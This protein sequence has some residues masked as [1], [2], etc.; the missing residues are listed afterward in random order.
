MVSTTVYNKAKGIFARGINW[1][2]ED[3]RALLI[4]D[5]I[6]G[7]V[8]DP[9]HVSLDEVLAGNEEWAGTGYS[10]PTLATSGRTLNVSNDDDKVYLQG[11]SVSFGTLS[12]DGAHEIT[13]VVFYWGS[14]TAEDG[15]ALTNVPL[16]CHW[17]GDNFTPDGTPFVVGHAAA[18][19]YVTLE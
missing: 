16:V 8:F 7:S 1:A 11:P 19:G 18:S 13:H 12:A 6:E 17:L 5:G 4:R 10:R 2:D 9:D 3:I 15:T 14:G